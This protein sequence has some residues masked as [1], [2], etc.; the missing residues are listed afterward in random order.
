MDRGAW[1]ATVHGVTE[2]D[3]TDRLSTH[4]PTDMCDSSCQSVSEEQ[5]T[6]LKNGHK[7]RTDLFQRHTNGQQVH[8]KMFNITDRQR[9]ATQATVRYLLTPFR[10]AIIKNPTNSKCWQGCGKKVTLVHCQQECKS[11][12]PYQTMVQRFLKKLQIEL[13]YDP[14]ISLLGIYPKKMETLFRKLHAPKCSQWHHLQW[15][16]HG[17]NLSVHQQ[18]NG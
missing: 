10:K 2:S 7:T 1:W 8:I 11:V 18:M 14:A 16:R 3:T 17:S 15:P 5:A 12:E 9:K 4:A 13:P 6:W